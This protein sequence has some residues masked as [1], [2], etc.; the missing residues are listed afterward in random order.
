[1]H[2]WLPVDVS[3]MFLPKLPTIVNPEE[4]VLSARFVV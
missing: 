1:M 3:E 4:A 2:L